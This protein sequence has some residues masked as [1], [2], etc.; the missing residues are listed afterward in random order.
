MDNPTN[1]SDINRQPFY[2]HL[3]AL[4]VLDTRGSV[5]PTGTFYVGGR[6]RTLFSLRR[7]I[8]L[9]TT[10]STIPFWGIDYVDRQSIRK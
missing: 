9:E 6:K 8:G 7:R 3:K 5:L 1:M 4:L 2:P 10:T